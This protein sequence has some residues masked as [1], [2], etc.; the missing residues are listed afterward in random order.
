MRQFRISFTVQSLFEIAEKLQAPM[1]RPQPTHLLWSMAAF[2][3]LSN[4][5]ASRAQYAKQAP[6]ARQRFE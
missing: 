2:L 6:Q 3:S 4:A 1:Q 5:M